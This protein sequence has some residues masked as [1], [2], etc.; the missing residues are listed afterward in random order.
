M[1]LPLTNRLRINLLA[2]SFG[3]CSLIVQTEMLRLVLSSASGGTL[4]VGAALGS[5]LIWIAF[6]AWLGGLFAGRLRSLPLIAVIASWFALPSALFA[7]F[8]LSAL[9]SIIHIQP[10][11]LIRFGDLCLHSALACGPFALLI[12][13]SFPVFARLACREEIATGSPA[14]LFIGGLWAAEA[15][16]AFCAGALFTWVLAGRTDPVFDTVLFGSLPMLAAGLALGSRKSAA[17]TGGLAL[18]VSISAYSII[19]RLQKE[20][21]DLYWQGL[22]APGELLSARWTRY[23]H[24]L[25][26]KL[27]DQTNIYD[28]GQPLIGFPDPYNAAATAALLLSQHDSPSSVLV[29]GPSAYGPAQALLAAGVAHV[30]SLDP[31]NQLERELLSRLPEE[32]LEPLHGGGYQHIAEDAR[33]YLGRPCPSPLRCEGQG[34]AGWDLI[35]LN[36][37]GP[38]QM[39]ASRFYTPG[40]FRLARRALGPAGGLLAL[41][42][43]T[44]A[45]VLLPAQLDQAAAVWASLKGGFSHLALGAGSSYCYIFATDSDSLVSENH[46]LLMARLARHEGRVPNLTRYLIPVYFDSTR[47]GPLK[48]ALEAR[49]RE[50][51]PHTDTTPV[52]WFHYL[53]LWARLARQ[54]GGENK[55]PG[56]LEKALELADRDGARNLVYWPAIAL[57]FVLAGLWLRL[58]F[59]GNE[60]AALARAAALSIGA[61]GFAAMGAT[62]TLIYLCQLVFGALFHQVA[63][64][65]AVFMLALALGSWWGSKRAGASVSSFQAVSF[66]AFLISLSVSF[67]AAGLYCLEPLY[68]IRGAWG[69]AA[70]YLIFYLLVAA[71]GLSCGAFFPWAAAIHN[72]A[73]GIH[74]TGATAAALD[75]ADHLGASAGAVA[76]GVI[77]VPAA[78]IGPVCSGLALAM[79]CIALF[80]YAVS[81]RAN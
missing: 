44:S 72:R 7:I 47:T 20:F 80:W 29:I 33:S 43:P 8:Y 1:A 79:I 11:E 3:A 35:W 26:A 60:E 41:R 77:A 28:N 34:P 40:F 51:A 68:G 25:F 69:P 10:G 58:G 15:A 4:A 32:M 21:S 67:P 59:R 46:E 38:S 49:S 23:S 6:G 50:L 75:G 48:E 62:V 2:G 56:L 19:P 76:V 61:A 81:A 5:W 64:I 9:R 18:I 53:R 37:D 66:L 13:F 22:G 73:A 39:N 71:V 36:L 78:G 12:G 27:A 31:D 24:L 57:L 70:A 14:A 65:S 63:L 16:G 55:N 45:N 30:T 74:R 42:L 52:A 54:S 17:L